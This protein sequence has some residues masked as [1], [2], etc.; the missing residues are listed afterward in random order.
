MFFI[1]KLLHPGCAGDGV[2]SWA[3]NLTKVGQS[4]DMVCT[5]CAFLIFSET[6]KV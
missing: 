2:K 6:C 5:V 4:D 3:G 1:L